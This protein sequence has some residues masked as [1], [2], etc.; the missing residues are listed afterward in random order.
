MC[1]GQIRELAKLGDAAS[2]DAEERLAQSL[3]V[4]VCVYYVCACV[5]VCV[6][7]CVIVLLL[8]PRRLA[9]L[10]GVVESRSLDSLGFRV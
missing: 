8:T 4:I 6:C 2:P 1:G 5:C 3:E 7:V 10:L 9:S